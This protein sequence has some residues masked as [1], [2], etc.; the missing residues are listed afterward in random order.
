[1]IGE[2]VCTLSWDEIPTWS[3]QG[4]EAQT[5]AQ[6]LNLHLKY[7]DP[8]GADPNPPYTHAQ[9]MAKRFEGEVVE[10]DELDFDP[11]VLY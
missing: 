7:F 6:A 3:C 8:S 10:H 11:D 4:P 5:F 9:D 1:M 2:T